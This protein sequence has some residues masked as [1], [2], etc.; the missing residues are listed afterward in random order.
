MNLCTNGYCVMNTFLV[1]APVSHKDRGPSVL[2]PSVT[3]MR[4]YLPIH[5]TMRLEGDLRGRVN[6]SSNLFTFARINGSF[7]DHK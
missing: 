4:R 2:H 5:G 1:G 7:D 3:N 6:E